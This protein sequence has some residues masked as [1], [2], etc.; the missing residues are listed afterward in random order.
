MIKTR[1]VQLMGERKQPRQS[2]QMQL[3]TQT[4]V[5]QNAV[6]VGGYKRFDEN[7]H[8]GT[9]HLLLPKLSYAVSYWPAHG[10]M[11]QRPIVVRTMEAVTW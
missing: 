8:T 10:F 6:A 3:A 4:A 11:S 2:P 7:M 5:V 1:A 9:M